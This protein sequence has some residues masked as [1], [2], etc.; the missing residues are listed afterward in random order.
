MKGNVL[1]LNYDCFFPE[2]M[3]SRL[4]ALWAA[5]QYHF[6]ATVTAHSAA[7]EAHKQARFEASATPVLIL[8]LIDWTQWAPLSVEADTYRH[9]PELQAGIEGAVRT[10]HNAMVRLTSAAPSKHRPR[11]WYVQPVDA[12]APQRALT[13]GYFA[14]MNWLLRAMGQPH[15]T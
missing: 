13:V 8:L 5:L 4:E 1:V 2:F 7:W 14:G 3:V 6:G 11:R 10:V 9:S 12:T 15:C